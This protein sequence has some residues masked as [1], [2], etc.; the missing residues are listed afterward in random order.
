MNFYNR[1]NHRHLDVQSIN[2]VLNQIGVFDSE[3]NSLSDLCEYFSINRSTSHSVIE[4]AK[5]TAQ[6]FFKITNILKSKL[7][8]II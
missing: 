1:I 7:G 3:L 5:L 2:Y 6:V 8:N 4:D